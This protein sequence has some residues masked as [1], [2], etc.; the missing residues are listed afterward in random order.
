[1]MRGIENAR[2]RS[3]RIDGR[4][5]A[6]GGDIARKVRSGVEVRERRRRSGIGVIVGGHVDGL[7]RR[8]GSVL[9]GSDALLQLAHL[10]GEVRLVS[11][12]G[13]HAAEQRRY[14]RT[15][16]R[17]PENVVDEQQYVLLFLIAEVLGDGQAGEPDAQAR[18]G[19]LGHLA[20]DERGLRLM[21]VVRIDNA[22]FLELEPQVVAFARALAD[23]RE[24]GHA[25]VL[26]G[27]VVDEF[28][29]D[30]GLADAGA[31]EQS[32]LAA[33]EI[34]LEQIDH[35]DAGLEHLQFGGLLLEGRRAR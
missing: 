2:G 34:R 13:R 8:D 14:F 21:E 5:D 17:E 25:A 27:E 11:D 1:M 26:H 19:R 28:L 9:G 32:D 29:N 22:G 10:G 6:D 7:H 35:L 23:A 24:H 16:L 4:V 33:A 15:R 18:A 31:A 3:Q 30:D 12:G 20:V